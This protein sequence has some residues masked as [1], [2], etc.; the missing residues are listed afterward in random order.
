MQ[1]SEPLSFLRILLNDQLEEQ[2]LQFIEIYLGLKHITLAFSLGVLALSHPFLFELVEPLV[3][4]DLGLLMQF[5]RVKDSCHQLL[6][7]HQLLPIIHDFALLA[8]YVHDGC[9]V[10]L[11]KCD[12]LENFLL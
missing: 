11:D 4:D 10:C 12:H 8:V 2:G 1:D 6:I 9:W 3:N 5:H 7:R